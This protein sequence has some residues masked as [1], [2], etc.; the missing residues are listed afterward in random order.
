MEYSSQS[1]GIVDLKALRNR[2]K[3]IMHK[4]SDA[5]FSSIEELHTRH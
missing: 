1:Y 5:Q 4:N 3:Y 2:N